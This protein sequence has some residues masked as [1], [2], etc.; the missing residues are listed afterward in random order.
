VHLQHSQ[1][2]FSNLKITEPDYEKDQH[3]YLFYEK[4]WTQTYPLYSNMAG[5]IKASARASA[6]QAKCVVFPT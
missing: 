5:S 1:R 6:A 4:L 3:L 2:F